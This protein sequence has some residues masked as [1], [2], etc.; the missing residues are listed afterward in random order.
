MNTNTT[1]TSAF[2]ILALISM[3]AFSGCSQKPSS[4]EIAAQ[5][6]AAMADEKAKEQ[7]ATPAPA[8]E[9]APAAKTVTPKAA[10]RAK[11]VEHATPVQAEPPAPEKKIYCANCGEVISVKEVEVAGKSSGL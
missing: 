5:V 9:P 3:L 7:A 8:P 1:R 2:G 4:E 6:K 11:P 10:A